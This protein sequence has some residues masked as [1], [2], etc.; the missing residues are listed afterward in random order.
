MTKR[1]VLLFAQPERPITKTATQVL[2]ELAP[3]I[4][5][6]PVERLV[7]YVRDAH[8]DIPSPSPFGRGERLPVAA[9]DV[10]CAD[11][12]GFDA[13]DALL[14]T[15]P[16]DTA[17]YAVDESVYR[18]YGDNAH[19]APRD[20]PDGERSP[21]L[22]TLNLVV[23]PARYSE[24]EWVERWFGIM[25]PVSEGIQPR[26]RYVRNRVI[27]RPDPDAPPWDGIV[28]ECWPSAQHVTNPMWFFGARGRPLRFLVNV[29]RILWAVA[30]FTSITRVRTVPMSEWFLRT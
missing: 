9:L 30:S 3:A 7:V 26:T 5:D 19:A 24:T 8:S 22:C 13:I 23:R 21:G 20:W 25:S 18:D 29:G 16:F 28:I 1:I 14:A 11:D 6:R 12:A 15:H 27:G 4:L 10:W 2:D 17:S